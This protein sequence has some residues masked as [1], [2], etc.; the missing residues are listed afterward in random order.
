[1]EMMVRRQY[2]LG[3]SKLGKRWITFLYS[4]HFNVNRIEGIKANRSIK[5]ASCAWITMRPQQNNS[6][7]ATAKGTTAKE[8]NDIL[9]HNCAVMLRSSLLLPGCRVHKLDHTLQNNTTYKKISFSA[10]VRVYGCNKL[11]ACLEFHQGEDNSSIVVKSFYLCHLQVVELRRT[12]S[13]DCS[14]PRDVCGHFCGFGILAFRFDVG[15]LTDC[16]LAFVSCCFTCKRTMKVT[17]SPT[18]ELGPEGTESNDA[19]LRGY[20]VI[21]SPYYHA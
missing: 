11:W 14:Y 19:V 10:T 5:A 12:S 8:E 9:I 7:Q 2:S 13:T 3:I 1:M 4:I 20:V 17:G 6:T 16:L 18:N 15:A 21:G